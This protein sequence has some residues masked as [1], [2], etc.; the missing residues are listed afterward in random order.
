MKIM[1]FAC[2]LCLALGLKAAAAQEPVAGE[3]VDP[4]YQSVIEAPVEAAPLLTEET[5]SRPTY[6]GEVEVAQA[7]KPATTLAPPVA[8]P[9][10]LR[11]AQ[12]APAATAIDPASQTVPP[13]L[14]YYSEQVRRHDD[15]AQA[16]RRKAELRAEQRMGRIAAMKWFGFSNA[17]PQ[18]SPIPM[19][20][21]YSPAWVGNGLDPYDWVGV[22]WPSTA[23]RIENYNYDVR[24]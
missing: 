24:R 22:S 6:Q 1:R 4:N 11:P 2:F 20:G 16:V 5:V 13:E 21:A 19:M 3:A 23:L 10:E 17:R 9:N 7:T 14:W 12:P 8:H 15:P 18:A